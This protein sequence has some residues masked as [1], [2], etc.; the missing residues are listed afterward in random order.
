MGRYSLH[1][2]VCPDSDPEFFAQLRRYLDAAREMAVCEIHLERVDHRHHLATGSVLPRAELRSGA[3]EVDSAEG[4][5]GLCDRI[6]EMVSRSGRRSEVTSRPAAALARPAYLPTLTGTRDGLCC[7]A[8][9]MHRQPQQELCVLDSRGR[10]VAGLQMDA[11]GRFAHASC[12]HEG[13]LYLLGGVEGTDRYSSRVLAVTPE[14]GATLEVAHLH[15]GRHKPQLVALENGKCLVVGGHTQHAGA[16]LTEKVDL[17]TGQVRA[18]TADVP[19]RV[20][21]AVAAM[22]TE[23]VVI[24]GGTLIGD[25]QR[26]AAGPS[27][28]VLAVDAGAGGYRAIGRLRC[29]R[30]FHSAVIDPATGRMIVCG[31]FSDH[32]AMDHL[33][34]FDLRSGETVHQARLACHRAGHACVPFPGG[35]LLIGGSN[36][37]QMVSTI[38]LVDG[39]GCVRSVGDMSVPRHSFGYAT[40]TDGIV[41][42]GG[43]RDGKIS[44]AVECLDIGQ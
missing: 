3:E 37:H 2:S 20:G 43:V 44:D 40:V 30:A 13:A 39:E 7:L 26:F 42:A 33:E 8:G 18:F 41:I 17:V 22:G 12:W 14:T 28:E 5:F 10:Q 38:E 6:G 29:A 27:D 36:G 4:R 24:V 9:G 1:V 21:H 15:A 16:P 31:G 25:L 34:V 35:W 19:N 11:P 32:K 23:T